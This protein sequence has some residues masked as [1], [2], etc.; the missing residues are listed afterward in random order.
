MSADCLFC[1]IVAGDMDA[2]VVYADDNVVAFRD[3]N[4]QAPTHVLVVPRVHVDDLGG[5]VEQQP[6]LAGPL[7]AGVAAVVSEL[8]LD[9][10]RVVANTGAEAGQSIFHLHLHVLAG[11]TLQA[12]MG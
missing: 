7:L 2:D 10:Y 3:I 1:D 9:D 4:P 6:Q 11:R 5:L 8:G 12:M